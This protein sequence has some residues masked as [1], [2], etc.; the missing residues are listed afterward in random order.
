M[1]NYEIHDDTARMVYFRD[2][3][4]NETAAPRAYTPAEN[5]AADLLA[6]ERV[7]STNYNDLMVKAS[8]ALT[9]NQ[10]TITNLQTAV[11]TLQALST[12]TWANQTQRDNALKSNSAQSAVVAQAAIA[13]LR[14]NNAL[15]RIVAG[16]L[17]SQA[18]T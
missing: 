14:Q 6:A 8:T 3:N 5:A 2:A 9:N 18:G 10:T 4:G 17:D 16:F 12:A 7:A 13:A 11:N 15:I 1:A